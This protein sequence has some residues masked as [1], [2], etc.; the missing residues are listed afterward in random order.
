MLLQIEIGDSIG[1]GHEYTSGLN[2]PPNDLGFYQHPI[3]TGLK[4]GMYSDDTQMSLIIAEMVIDARMGS[5]VFTELDVANRF[6]SGFKRDPRKGYSRGLQTLLEEVRNGSE[7][8]SRIN[9]HG[10]TDKNGAAMRIA[11]LVYLTDNLDELFRINEIVSGITHEGTAIEAARCV[12]VCCWALKYK[13][14]SLNEMLE[15][16]KTYFDSSLKLD[17]PWM[18]RVKVSNDL[19][20]ITVRAAIT[21]V[22]MS[23]G[24]LSDVI[25][26]AIGLGGDTDTV[27]S[28]ASAIASQSKDIKDDITP[29][30]SSFNYLI[31]QMENSN[32]G[33]NYIKI[34]DKMLEGSNASSLSVSCS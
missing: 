9:E 23:N 24:I 14:S 26:T 29:K 33:V 2:A 7:L 31:H 22:I 11:P 13:N 28:I 8:L 5:F 4:P 32:Y 21:S 17:Q 27:A 1:V 6:V 19:G 30:D 34:I 10:R 15:Y 16:I 18:E 12:L 25:K 20:L 3:H